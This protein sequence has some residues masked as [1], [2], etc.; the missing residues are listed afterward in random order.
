VTLQQPGAGSLP[1][2]LGS[3]LRLKRVFLRTLIISLT[4]CALVSVAAL[5]LGSFT[6]FTAKVLATLG[7]LALHS[8]A[9]MFCAATLEQR[10]W[11]KLSAAGLIVFGASLGLLITCI[12]WPGWFDEPTLRAAI[13]FAA[14]AVFYTLAIPAADL[15]EGGGRRPLAGAGLLVCAVAFVMV[16]VCVWAEDQ[17]SLVFAKAT[18]I[19]TVVA[20]SFAH[21]TLL[22]RV[23][24]GRGLEWLLYLALACVWGLGA[25][26]AAS[27]AWGIEQEFWYRWLG[28]VGVGCVQFV[29][30]PDHGETAAG[31]ENREVAVG[32]RLG[33][34][35]LPALHRASDS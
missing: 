27:I 16:L 12:W 13:S 18:A 30:A 35:A 19:A 17:H 22:I 1:A 34:V 5:L 9:A 14:L 10:R 7:A 26:V 21:M 25:M 8:G 11:P 28:A 31:W 3:R 33:R 6:Q 20:F 32:G 23:P 4:T 24:G 15:W 29:C 2:I